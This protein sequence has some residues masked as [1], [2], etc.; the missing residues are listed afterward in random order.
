[1]EI[2]SLKIPPMSREY[3]RQQA[4]RLRNLAK[5]ATTLTIQQHLVDVAL[6][7]EKLAE[8]A[9]AGGRGLDTGPVA[10]VW[11]EPVGSAFYF[12]VLFWGRPLAYSQAFSEPISGRLPQTD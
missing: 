9:E 11:I 4:A 3:Y 8:G 1:M 10:R 5:D 12:S 2:T 6:E 7:Y